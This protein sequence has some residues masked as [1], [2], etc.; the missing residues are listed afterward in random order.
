MNIF[1]TISLV[2]LAVACVGALSAMDKADHGTPAGKP[3][4]N[5]AF[6]LLRQGNARFVTGATH[7]PHTDADRLALAG[8]ED[9]GKY[10]YA[11]ILACSDSRVPVE[12][13]FDAG[14]MD[15]FTI[16][17]A[18]N[19]CGSQ[20]IGTVEYGLAHVHTPLL[21]VLG[22]S[23]C[24]A[25]TAVVKA[26]R[27]KKS[28]PAKLERNIPS[29]LQHIEPAVAAT[30]QEGGSRHSDAT[31]HHVAAA[32]EENVYCAIEELFRESPIT[33]QL[34]DAGA[35][36]VVGAIYAVDT[37]Q[38]RWL[39]ENEVYRR[40]GRAE[41]DPSHALEAYASEPLAAEPKAQRS[42]AR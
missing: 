22:H 39:P 25:V 8:R 19:V 24:G 1:R 28:G 14:V 36:R 7:H 20:V 9:Q 16:R 40:L 10:A 30:R 34:V 18:G 37:G 2:C 38:I 5:E 12:R 33:R 41:S 21:V 4:A 35:V 13:I 15:L 32:V 31:G 29:L 3:T 26:D 17:V 11:T 6:D 42:T 27:Q 23:Q